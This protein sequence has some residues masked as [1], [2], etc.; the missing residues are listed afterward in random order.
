MASSE[1]A[2]GGKEENGGE[3]QAKTPNSKRRRTS[4]GGNGT[5]RE[6]APSPAATAGSVVETA[7]DK[8]PLGAELTK[9]YGVAEG[10]GY[11]EVSASAEAEDN[12]NAWFSDPEADIGTTAA[13]GVVQD[14]ASAAVDWKRGLQEL[15]RNAV[16]RRQTKE[17][18]AG[19]SGPSQQQRRRPSAEE[20]VNLVRNAVEQGDWASIV[21]PPAGQLPQPPV[22]GA[23]VKLLADSERLAVLRASASKYEAEPFDRNASGTWVMQ[24]LEQGGAC[25]AG[26]LELRE[27]LRPLL[28]S[29]SQSLGSNRRRGDVLS[30]VG[31]WRLVVELAAAQR[32]ATNAAATAVEEASQ[33]IHKSKKQRS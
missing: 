26:R 2:D 9:E 5:S 1:A 20:L 15:R 25:L 12:D 19:G 24:V 21:S 16:K 13:G 17:T 10:F 18:L 30:C 31:S 27:A 29:V 8:W 11:M 32:E 7:V 33:R 6:A 22:V 4:K 23:A 14:A 3:A 28:G